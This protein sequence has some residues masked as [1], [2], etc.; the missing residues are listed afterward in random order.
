VIKRAKK[1]EYGISLVIN[2]KQAMALPMQTIQAF[3]GLVLAA[4]LKKAVE[5]DDKKELTELVLKERLFCRDVMNKDEPCDL[6]NEVIGLINP[7]IQIFE[8]NK[9]IVLIQMLFGLLTEQELTDRLDIPKNG[10]GITRNDTKTFAA[11]CCTLLVYRILNYA[12]LLEP[13]TYEYLEENYVEDVKNWKKRLPKNVESSK[14]ALMANVMKYTPM[15]A[16]EKDPKKREHLAN[17]L[18]LLVTLMA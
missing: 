4:K 3:Y 2:I 6:L 9:S 7:M 15:L 13:A 8:V 5:R 11:C 10:L 18:A 1:I 16:T 14:D 12:N 17:Y